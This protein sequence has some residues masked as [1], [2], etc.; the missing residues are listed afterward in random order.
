MSNYLLYN[1][2]VFDTGDDSEL[3]A[4]F[5]TSTG[6]PK[7][8]FWPKAVLLYLKVRGSAIEHKAVM[9]GWFDL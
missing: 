5:A 7:D 8:S 2:S 3:A 6:L 9:G 4:T 1:C